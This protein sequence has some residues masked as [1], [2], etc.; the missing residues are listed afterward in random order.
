MQM[1]V[2][3]VSGPAA[4]RRTGY[5]VLAAAAVLLLVFAAAATTSSHAGTMHMTTLNSQMTTRN[6]R[7]HLLTVPARLGCPCWSF[8]LLALAFEA[9][10]MREVCCDLD[11]PLHMQQAASFDE[12]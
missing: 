5:A 12:Q 2:M 10:T 8:L 4:M 7:L 6:T 9:A 3:E 11:Q 1:Q